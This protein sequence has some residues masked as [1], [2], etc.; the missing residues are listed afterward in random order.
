MVTKMFGHMIGKTVEV[1]IDDMLVKSLRE[2]NHVA[3]LLQVFDIL[4]GSQYAS[5]RPNVPSV[6]VLANFWAMW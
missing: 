3:D 1:Y 2:E 4:R 6:L 5:M